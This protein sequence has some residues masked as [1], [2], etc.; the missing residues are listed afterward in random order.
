MRKHAVCFSRT[1][2][3]ISEFVVV[4]LLPKHAKFDLNFTPIAIIRGCTAR[5]V[6]DLVGNPYE[7]FSRDAAQIIIKP[8]S[9]CFL[10]LDSG[11]PRYRKEDC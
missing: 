10:L 3:R 8:H 6:S 11:R 7:R 5:F 1:A 9:K 4:P 2:Q